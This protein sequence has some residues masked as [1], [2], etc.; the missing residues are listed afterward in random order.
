MTSAYS[1][2]DN[3]AKTYSAPQFHMNDDVAKRIFMAACNE[4]TLLD[5]F[6]EDFSLVY[7]GEF[8]EKTGTF[9]NAN[10]FDNPD[11]HIVITAGFVKEM[12][13]NDETEV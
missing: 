8:D 1:V 4:G 3:K 7:I 2:Y 9:S 12:K 10:E 11:V 6:P 5:M 13:N